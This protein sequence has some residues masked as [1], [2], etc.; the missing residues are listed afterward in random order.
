MADLRKTVPRL[1][2]AA[3]APTPPATTIPLEQLTITY[4][5]SRG[6]CSTDRVPV[7]LTG[8]DLARLL[9]GRGG[10]ESPAEIAFTLRGLGLL[11]RAAGQSQDF[12]DYPDSTEEAMLAVESILS[13]LARRLYA[14]EDDTPKLLGVVVTIAPTDGAA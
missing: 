13:D 3:Q 10:P 5:R 12:A 8:P 11:C 14:L 6:F 1:A 4:E 9:A 2:R 7:T